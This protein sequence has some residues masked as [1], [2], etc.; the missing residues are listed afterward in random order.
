M[1]Y[2]NLG[3]SGVKV[4]KFCFG[5]MTFGSGFRGVGAV[6]QQDANAMVKYALDHGVNF[7]DTADVYSRGESEQVLG[8]ALK[9]AGV[10]RDQVIIATKVRG[11]MGDD[12][13]D[14]GLSRKHILDSAEKSLKRLQVEYIDLYQVHGWDPST[15][16][17]ETMEA[18]NDLVRWGKVR[19]LGAS[20]LAAWQLAKANAIARKHGWARFVTYQGYYS[21]VGRDIEHEVV[22][23]CLDQGMG[24]LTWSP[25]AGGLLTGKYRKGAPKGTR[26]SGE[27]KGFIPAD[28]RL[29]GKVLD[30]L[31]TV[32]KAHKTTLATAALAWLAQRP[33]VTSV[34]IGA[35]TEEQLEQNLAASELEMNAKELAALDAASATPL[36]YPQWMIERQKAY[37][38]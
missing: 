32:S 11:R 14:V 18:L 7:F 38:K 8:K 31:D 33:G 24:V 12:V 4:S 1:E 19:Y 25:L 20:N 6:S 3:S 35:R 36:P 10:P 9:A 21:L 16:L 30:A 29:L 15:P 17:K 13:N 5:T 22:P 23:L 28:E 26:L 34:I 37:H 2:V 27:L